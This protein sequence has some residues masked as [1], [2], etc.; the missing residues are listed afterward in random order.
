MVLAPGVPRPVSHGPRAFVVTT[1]RSDPAPVTA[2]RGKHTR[3]D[4]ADEAG[5][6]EQ[7][8]ESAQ[9]SAAPTLPRGVHARQLG[10]RVA[11]P[12]PAPEVLDFK[13]ARFFGGKINRSGESRILPPF[14]FAAS[15]PKAA[16]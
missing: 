1:G 10:S 2:Y 12:A 15:L 3:L 5:L 13:T 6:A 16:F 8:A 4:E 14:P 11:R 7:R 9:A